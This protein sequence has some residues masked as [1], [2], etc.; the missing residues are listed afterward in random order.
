MRATA[1][2]IFLFLLCY[3]EG[4]KVLLYSP[5]FGASHVSF[6]GKV[7]DVMVENGIDVTVLLPIMNPF[8]DSNG[9]K[10]AKTITIE[11]D[12]RVVYNF[13]TIEFFTQVWDNSQTNPL[14]EK[15]GLDFV[16]TNVKLT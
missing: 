6:M 14:A 10:L 1:S 12:P 3:V 8:F 5:R 13:E 2:C 11:T 7:A 4:I 15:L 9:T 16:R